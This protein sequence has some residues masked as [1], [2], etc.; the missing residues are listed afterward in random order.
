[1]FGRVPVERT[2]GEMVVGTFANGKL[3]AEVVEGIELMRGV[4][5]LV[6]FSMAALDLAVMSGSVRTNFTSIWTRWPGYCICSIG[7][8]TYFFFGFSAL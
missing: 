2:H 3:L 7:F 4:E 5:F 1:M 6:V 8:G